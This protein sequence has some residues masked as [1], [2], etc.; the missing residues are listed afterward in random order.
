MFLIPYVEDGDVKRALIG[1]RSES[2]VY[3]GEPGK[4][5]EE[6]YYRGLHPFEPTAGA[7]HD[8]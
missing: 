8:K 1:E 4:R 7:R 3:F 2:A 6:L 5:A